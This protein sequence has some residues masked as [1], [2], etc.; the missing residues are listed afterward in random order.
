MV[1][2]FVAVGLKTMATHKYELEARRCA[3]ATDLGAS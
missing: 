1:T 2:G 3:A